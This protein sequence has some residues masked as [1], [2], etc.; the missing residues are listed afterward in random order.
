[1]RDELITALEA[2]SVLE[3]A[4]AINKVSKAQVENLHAGLQSGV[5]TE[6]YAY[7]EAPPLKGH[8]LSSAAFSNSPSSISVSDARYFLEENRGRVIRASKAQE[9]EDIKAALINIS[10]LLITFKN[11]AKYKDVNLETLD[12]IKKYYNQSHMEFVR[13][14]GTTT[15][16]I[17]SEFIPFN[18]GSYG[19]QDLFKTISKDL[20]SY[21]RTNIEATIENN[22]PFYPMLNWLEQVFARMQDLRWED[23]IWQTPEIKR[24]DITKVLDAIIDGR[25]EKILLCAEKELKSR[26]SY[27]STSDATQAIT[28]GLM[29]K[30]PGKEFEEKYASE[31]LSR[32]SYMSI[33]LDRTSVNIL[34]MFKDILYTKEKKEI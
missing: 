16:D 18:I 9:K 30:E 1:M 2:F 27:L 28:L 34:K 4:V 17:V 31:C 24:V 5:I 32:V 21:L 11:G 6:A 12:A 26:L 20:S 10:E 22:K 29:G 13:S 3:N 23:V 19:Q 7:E 14:G 8:R 15:E 25:L 33:L